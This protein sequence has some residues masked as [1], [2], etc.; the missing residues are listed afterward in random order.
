VSRRLLIPLALALVAAGCGGDGE[1]SATED[2]GL[3]IDTMVD[4]AGPDAVK[5]V[6]DPAPGEALTAFVKSAQRRDIAALWNALTDSGRDRSAD[7]LADFK[8][9]FGQDVTDLIG[10]YAS[11]A[12][13]ASFR[14]S[15]TT[16]V[17]AIAGRRVDPLTDQ[18]EHDAFGVGFT[19]Q[20]GKWKLELPSPIAIDLLSPD[21]ELPTAVPAIV[22][23][24]EGYS[25]IIEVGVWIDD[26][27]Q[28]TPTEGASPTKL[29]IFAEPQEPVGP[30]NHTI[31]AYASIAQVGGQLPIGKAWTFVGAD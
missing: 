15:P 21:Q 6:A 27:Q 4:E 26:E 11:F 7:S 3:V 17:A 20:D 25:P 13:V 23:N 19:R 1:Q 10:T 5:A 16:A 18:S 22:V 29:T 9:R 14:T 2:R 24:V 12:V 8:A 31:L 28:P 30:G